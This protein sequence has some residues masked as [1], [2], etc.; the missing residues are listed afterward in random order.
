MPQLERFDALVLG[1]GTG[2]HQCSNQPAE[3]PVRRRHADRRL[4]PIEPPLRLAH[5]LHQ[6][7]EYDPLLGELELLAHQ[8]VDVQA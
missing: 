4:Q 7:L 5:R 8:P 2:G 1:S 6:L 3:R